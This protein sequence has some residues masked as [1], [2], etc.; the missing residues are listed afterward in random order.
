MAL[1]VWLTCDSCGS[2]APRDADAARRRRP[3]RDCAPAAVPYRTRGW[4]FR[5]ITALAC[6]DVPKCHGEWLPPWIR[7]RLSAHAELGKTAAG[8]HLSTK[9]S[10]DTLTLRVARSRTSMYIA[11]WRSCS[12]V[13]RRAGLRRRA[14]ARTDDSGGLGIDRQRSRGLPLS[15][16]GDPQWSGRRFS[17]LLCGVKL[18]TFPRR[19]HMFPA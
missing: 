2:G 16:R 5:A 18:R 6:I 11:H 4:V 10:R 19:S 7:A 15:C 12:C 13:C 1:L 3:G 8:A 14:R 17:R 9:R